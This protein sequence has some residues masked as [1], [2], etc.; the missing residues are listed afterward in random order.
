MK[1]L[2]IL[3]VLILLLLIYNGIYNYNL[4]INVRMT[5][6]PINPLRYLFF[7]LY[8]FLILLNLIE[9]IRGKFTY[10]SLKKVFYYMIFAGY[11]ICIFMFKYNDYHIPGLPLL[12]Y[13]TLVGITLF[14]LNQ[15]IKNKPIYKRVKK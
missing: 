15:I 1:T 8:F 10:G 9:F 14:M 11:L 3:I 2:R 5:D 13:F 6:R 12:G 4:M 7:G